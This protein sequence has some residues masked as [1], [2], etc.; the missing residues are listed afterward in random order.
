[1]LKLLVVACATIV[2]VPAMAN[3][4]PWQRSAQQK[5]LDNC[6]YFTVDTTTWRTRCIDE[7][8]MWSR[9]LASS[10]GGGSETAASPVP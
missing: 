10:R 1:M 3:A 7:D 9:A 8:V 4:Q 2:L 6:T 5:K